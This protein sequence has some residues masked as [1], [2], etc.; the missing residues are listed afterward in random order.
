[1][2]EQL[3]SEKRSEGFIKELSFRVGTIVPAV[4][5]YINCGVQNSS[6]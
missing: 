5:Q 2:Y 6:Q 1:M 3:C 4:R